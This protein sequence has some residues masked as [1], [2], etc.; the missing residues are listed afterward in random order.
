MAYNNSISASDP[1]AIEKL[2]AKLNKCKELQDVMKGVNAHWRKY[3]T[4]VGAPGI[5]E[6]HAK[7]I[8]NKIATTNRSWERQPFS[9]YDL[10]SNNQE[11]HRL[12]G[13]IKEITR[14]Q[15]VGFSGWEFEGGKAEINNDLDRLQLF[16]DERPDKD[17]CTVLKANGF[18]WSPT[19]GAWQRQLTQNAI[20][21]AN[22]ISFISPCDGR[23][24]REHQPKAPARSEGAR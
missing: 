15:E 4:C 16:F 13:R 17:K 20:Y 24:V 9:S 12:E 22:R 21:S 3:N 8:D 1:Q 14:N 5:T 19:N 10:S 2:T 7:K 6:E 23:S 11:I 18:H